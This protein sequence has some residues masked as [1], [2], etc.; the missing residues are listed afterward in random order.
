MIIR[1]ASGFIESLLAAARSAYPNECCGLVT[2]KPGL[3]EAIAPAR[4]V[5]PHPAT[6]FE[7]DPG[8]LIRTQREVRERQ[9]HVI[10][11]YHSHPNGSFEPSARD[12]A[13][14]THSGQTW[15]IVTSDIVAAWMAVTPDPDAE[16]LVHGCFMPVKLFPV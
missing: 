11:H 4:N 7:I 10:G 8:T 16:G 13:S 14:I 2:G 6:N 5:H 9:R 12:A 1:F 15:F 3:A